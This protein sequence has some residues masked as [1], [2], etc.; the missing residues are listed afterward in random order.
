[1]YYIWWPKSDGFMTLRGVPQ[2]ISSLSLWFNIGRKYPDPLPTVNFDIQKNIIG[3]FSDVLKM[4]GAKGIVISKKIIEILTDMKI[5]HLQYIPLILNNIRDGG[6][7]E[8]Y[9]ILN[10]LNLHNCFDINSS[11]LV[12]RTGSSKVKFIDKLVLD[13]NVLMELKEKNILLFRASEMRGLV[14]V[15]ESLKKRMEQEKCTGVQFVHPDNFH[16]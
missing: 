10:I 16:L 13:Q 1:M 4:P 5:P 15:H 11:K 3:S 7:R 12:F 6:T 9:K 14:F 2:K 8:N